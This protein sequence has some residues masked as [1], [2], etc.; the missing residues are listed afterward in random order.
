MISS[1]FRSI[2]L[3]GASTLGVAALVSL[4]PLAAAQQAPAP[5]AASAEALQV[6]QAQAETLTGT[7]PPGQLS[8][9]V[10]DASGVLSGNEVA[11]IEDAIVQFMME[12]QKSIFVVYLPSFG[13]Y[14]PAQWAEEAAA[15]NGGMNTLIVAIAT[16]DREYSIGADTGAGYWTEQELDDIDQAMYGPLIESDWAGA[17]LAAVTGA[18]SSGQISG[19]SAAWLGAGG[20]AVVGTG[21]G[22]WAYSRRTKK[23]TAEQQL[24]TA[25]ELSPGDTD[26]LIKLPVETLETRAQEAIVATDESVRHAREEL[27]I[28]VAEFGAERT[29]PFTKAMNNASGALQR[30]H[31]T[32]QQLNDAIPETDPQQRAMLVE[33]ISSCGLAQESLDEQAT[34]FAELRNLL[35]NAGAKL[36]EL[37][38]QGIALRARVEPAQATLEDLQSRYAPELLESIDDNVDMAVV[39]LEQ[40]EQQLGAGREL[41]AQPAGQQGGLVNAIR[42][43]E[44]ALEL[45][46]TLLLGVEHAD[47]DIAAAREGL[48]P[49]MDEVAEEIR[50]AEALKARGVNQGAKA[51]WEAL[52]AIVT[53]ARNILVEVRSQSDTDP[54]G[55]YATLMDTDT[56]LDT[57][58]DA[59]RESTASQER[60]L[61]LLDKQLAA[62]QS[63][64]QSAEDLIASRG[65][66]VQAQARTYLA[67]AQQ[68]SAQAIHGRISH[69]R[70]ATE[71]ARQAAQQAQRARQHA[72]SDI[73]A[74]RNRMT[75]RQAGSGVS[76]V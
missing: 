54:L 11:D 59:V 36:Q 28:A 47:Q 23:K 66:V 76:D 1:R 38:Q 57:Q 62:A 72:Q 7:I 46:D 52:D 69:T 34:K 60:Q 9:R 14:T 56:R 48:Q 32:Q 71:H 51:N 18:A 65:A 25:R 75:A 24:A 16:E 58:L 33:I 17:G 43:T 13:Q 19:E 45:T 63:Q 44:R 6:Q 8:N 20:L 26:A 29:R 74:Y 53:E 42:E 41:L 10:T 27:D 37:T 55:A 49:L 35:V 39:A 50:E 3:G 31:R 64:I 12:N 22:I 70:Q 5:G 15:A 21:A 2:L 68:L 61:A 30:A 73:T 67:N 40:A 4:A